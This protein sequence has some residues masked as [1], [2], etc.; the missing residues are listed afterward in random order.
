MKQTISI[1]LSVVLFISTVGIKVDKHFCASFLHSINVFE[2]FDENSCCGVEMEE[3]AGC[4]SDE[5]DYFHFE[6]KYAFS[7]YDFSIEKP[8]TAIF[9]PIWNKFNIEEKQSN[10]QTAFF[11]L[12]KPPPKE[13]RI[14][15]QNS[16]F[17]I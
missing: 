8:Y 4:C 6:E 12:I 13:R 10:P 11:T 15:I 5:V 16:V 2:E 9:I 17:I 7:I 14:H 3:E 1:L